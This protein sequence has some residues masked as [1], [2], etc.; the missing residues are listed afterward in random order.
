MWIPF[1]VH[2]EIR[3][4]V[5]GVS[6]PH[7]HVLVWTDQGLF[8]LWYFR[9]AFVNK[10]ATSAEADNAF[11]SATGSLTWNGT[12]Y[13]MLGECAPKNDPRRFTL[14]PSGDRVALDADEGTVQIL[15]AAN[16]VQQ[17]IENVSSEPWGVAAFSGD[18]KALVVADSSSVRLFR[19]ETITGK[20]RPRWA[21]VG[22][23]SDQKQLLRAIL[24]NPDE[25]TPRLIY[26]DWL[27]EH[28]DP[29]RA[30][31]IRVQC[32]LAERKQRTHVP[33]D[34]P[35]EQRA[36]E[37][38]KQLGT[39]WLA[40]LLV[41]R[42]LR[43]GGFYRG[44]P[45]VSVTNA[46]TLVRAEEKIWSAAPVEM[47]TLTGLS[48]N[49]ARVLAGSEV[50]GRIRELTLD[51]YYTSRDSEKPLRTLF[52]SPRMRTLRRLSLPHGIGESG[53]GVVVASPH[54]TGLEWLTIRPRTMTDSAADAILA[55]PALANLR[56][57][58]FTS[59][60]LSSSARKKLKARFPNA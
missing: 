16:R 55:A 23:A 43:W 45:G 34:D 6:L 48:G 36:F 1:T 60:Q 25:D 59:Y 7:G 56:G 49:S 12:A 22:G 39:R 15:D 9:S 18:G 47:V 28:G 57:G 41:I 54:L 11:D 46:T 2:G 19:Y 33:G 52:H 24:D 26:A 27:D 14:H 20:E 44:F 40:E 38:F 58:S 5:R 42:N 4:R 50:L 3:G 13:P 51:G 17:T 37:L 8:S 53:I 29:G 31:F 10:L 35:E 21:A 30:E 32:R